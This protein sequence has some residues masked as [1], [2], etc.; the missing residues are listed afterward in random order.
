MLWFT[1]DLNLDFPAQGYL[2][3]YDALEP[4]ETGYLTSYLN[5][6]GRLWFDSQDLT[7]QSQGSQEVYTVTDPFLIRT[8]T[9]SPFALTFLMTVLGS[10]PMTLYTAVHKRRRPPDQHHEPTDP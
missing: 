7:T 9:S 2:F 10:T 8:A 4:A 3:Q 1:G 5:N 6:G